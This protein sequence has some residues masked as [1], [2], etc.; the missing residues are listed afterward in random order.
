MSSLHPIKEGLDTSFKRHQFGASPTENSPRSLQPWNVIA[1]A[2]TTTI[3]AVRLSYARREVSL[4][5]ADMYALSI[6][7]TC[8]AP[9]VDL[10]KSALDELASHWFVKISP[11]S[12]LERDERE[13]ESCEQLVY[14]KNP[15]VNMRRFLLSAIKPF[16]IW[17]HIVPLSLLNAAA[18]VFSARLNLVPFSSTGT[19]LT[20]C[21]QVLPSFVKKGKKKKINLLSDMA[22]YHFAGR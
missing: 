11:C 16:L 22:R 10:L 6:I 5:C 21:R 17:K 19:D 9:R 18:A 4:E 2:T 20:L 7:V 12:V 8:D 15:L 13:S 14:G 3:V 1:G